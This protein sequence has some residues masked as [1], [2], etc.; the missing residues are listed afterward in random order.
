MW[1]YLIGGASSLIL[2]A[3]GFFLVKTMAEPQNVIPNAPTTGEIAKDDPLAS[4][5]RFAAKDAPPTATE[6]SKEEKRFNRYDKDKNG[7]VSKPEYLASRQKA[8]AKLDSN[9]D[10]VLSF[11]EYAVKTGLKFA[12][13]DGD[14]TGVLNRTE[15][16]TTRVIRKPKLKLNCPPE[17]QSAPAEA[18]D[19]EA[20]T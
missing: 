4:P 14:K 19:G 18:S 12:K 9:G 1:R 13:A 3:A 6:L 8:Y 20:D 7:A 11:D 5:M 15:F 2:V 16:S 17:R 10:G